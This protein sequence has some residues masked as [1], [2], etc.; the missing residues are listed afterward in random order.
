MKIRKTEKL[1]SKTTVG[2]QFNLTENIINLTLL[3]QTDVYNLF[4]VTQQLRL[5][6][7]GSQQ[8]NLLFVTLSVSE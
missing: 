7:R 5:E 2:R 4:F 3:Q 8:F 1:R 6:A